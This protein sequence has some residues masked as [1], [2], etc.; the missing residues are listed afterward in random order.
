MKGIKTVALVSAVVI[1]IATA[2]TWA[3]THDV[4]STL[5][6]L[7][8]AS[9]IATVMMAVTIYEL[10][11][12]IKELNFEAVSATYGMMDES[13][14]D[15]LRK[16][17]SWWDQENGKMC[18][19][20][21][22]FMKDNEKR[23]IVG[24]ASKILNR[25]GYFVYREFVGDWFIQEQYGGLILDSF[26][27]MRPYLKAL[28]DE[29]ECRE[30]EGSENEKCTNGPWFIRR[31][32]LLLVVISYVYLCENFPEQCRGIFEKYGMNVEK[33]VPKGWLHREI[34]EWLRRKGYWEYL[35]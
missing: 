26:L 28:R 27:A 23:K 13:L 31:F 14:K 16:I 24:E 15:K 9:T 6:V 3:F 30:G 19:P 34:R 5:I 21:E 11:I 22:E 32:Y 2:A 4:N 12:A 1:F 10:D 8:L 25:V 29:A 33:P 20:V 18:L 35:A 17:R 7:T